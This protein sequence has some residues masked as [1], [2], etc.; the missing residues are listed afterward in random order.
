VKHFSLENGAKSYIGIHYHTYMYV[1]ANL[2]YGNH[3]MVLAWHDYCARHIR[4]FLFDGAFLSGSTATAM[5]ILTF[6]LG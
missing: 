3:S 2:L 4:W 5:V 1:G 6:N